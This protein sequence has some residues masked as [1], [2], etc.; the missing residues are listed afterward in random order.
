VA[1]GLVV[2][3]SGMALAHAQPDVDIAL[4]GRDWGPGLQPSLLG[5]ALLAVAGLLTLVPRHRARAVGWCLGIALPLSLVR[6]SELVAS[7]RVAGDRPWFDL[8]WIVALGVAA[9]AAAVL[10][11]AGAWGRTRWAP[12][13]L[14]GAALGSALVWAALLLIDPYRQQANAGPYY[15]GVLSGGRFGDPVPAGLW[16]MGTAA[17]VAGWS[18]PVSGGCRRPPAAAWPWERRLVIGPLRVARRGPFAVAG[19]ALAAARRGQ[20]RLLLVGLTTVVVAVAL[21]GTTLLLPGG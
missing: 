2:S 20:R 1:A 21:V 12:T 19:A 4:R 8:S 11:R 7:A 6:A 14:V 18:T 15:G 9:L 17:C 16:R 3:F 10:R 13:W 5:G